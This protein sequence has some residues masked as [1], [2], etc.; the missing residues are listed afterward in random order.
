VTIRTAVIAEEK[1]DSTE[2][3][4]WERQD[5]YF[6]VIARAIDNWTDRRKAVSKSAGS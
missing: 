2:D 6:L 3:V 4:D 1:Q 5:V